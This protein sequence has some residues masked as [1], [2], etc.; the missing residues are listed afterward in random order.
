[1]MHGAFTLSRG[2]PVRP[3]SDERLSERAPLRNTADGYDS[4]AAAT[5]LP[6]AVPLSTKFR[7]AEWILSGVVFHRISS[8]IGPQHERPSHQQ[9][10]PGDRGKPLMTFRSTTL[11]NYLLRNRSASSRTVETMRSSTSDRHGPGRLLYRMAPPPSY[12]PSRRTRLEGMY[13]ITSLL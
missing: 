10:Q 8:P 6:S 13:A 7:L 3:E 5:M 9:Q 2:R 1:M 11:E 4:A 12:P